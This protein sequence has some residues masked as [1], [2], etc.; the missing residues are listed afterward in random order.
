M[1]ESLNPE[2]HSEASTGRHSQ[3]LSPEQHRELQEQFHRARDLLRHDP[4]DH[5]RAQELLAA[6]I[7]RDPGNAI[8]VREFVELNRNTARTRR[9]DGRFEEAIACWQR[10]EQADPRDAEA[11]RMIAELTLEKIRRADSESSSQDPTGSEPTT[12]PAEDAADPAAESVARVSPQPRKLI[13]TPRQELEQAIVQNPEDETNYLALA[14]LLLQQQR[15]FEAQQTLTKALNV[16][17]DLRI[18]ERLEDVNLLRAQE[19]VEIAKRRAAE[20]RTTNAYELVKQQQDTAQRLE[21]EISAARCDRYPEDRSLRF[22]LGMNLKR[23]GNL[24]EALEPLQAGLEVEEHRAVA[25]LEIGEI[26]QHYRQFPKALQCYRQ[27]AQLAASHGREHEIRKLS[28]YRAGILAASMQLTDSAT[29]YLSELLRVDPQ[30]K[31]AQG[32]LDKLK[33][34]DEDT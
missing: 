14:E 26:L 23:M 30:Y 13:L 7:T 34:I 11:P 8:Y 4:P 18:V 5:D 31:D 33:E 27:A 6:C 3:R 24:R 10:I 17:S 21:L 16:A 22:K 25:S 2:S 20:D 28:L 9:T 19:Q 29:Q 15:T 1:A 12:A 32:H